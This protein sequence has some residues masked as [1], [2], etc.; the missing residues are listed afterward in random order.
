MC[1]A[2]YYPP[3]NGGLAGIF[4][5]LQHHWS[6]PSIT[7]LLLSFV[8][9]LLLSSCFLPVACSPEA[10]LSDSLAP[11]HTMHCRT[12][13][14]LQQEVSSLRAELQRANMQPLIEVTSAQWH[15]DAMTQ[16]MRMQQQQ[17]SMAHTDLHAVTVQLSEQTAAA[18]S[19]IEQLQRCQLHL[20][21][22]EAVHSS[23][24]QAAQEQQQ[25]AAEQL[26]LAQCQLHEAKEGHAAE[27]RQA[28]AQRQAMQQQ[29]DELQQQLHN[30]LHR[31]EAELRALQAAGEAASDEAQRLQRQLDQ[32]R[33][34]Q[35]TAHKVSRAG[36]ASTY[37]HA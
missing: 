26:S 8:V 29:Q 18:H 31:H 9:T 28:A 36:T 6:W 17:L 7:C 2:V 4:F 5:K 14:Q 1:W 16:Q 32:E 11:E 21:E 30:M 12:V 10:A 34:S 3:D 15:V 24:L 35:E 19:A 27:L 25:A 33:A 23:Q 13:L 37:W 20:S 22:R